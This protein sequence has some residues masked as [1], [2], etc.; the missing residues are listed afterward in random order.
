MWGRIMLHRSCSAQLAARTGAGKEGEAQMAADA[1]ISE[2]D[3][4]DVG[5]NNNKILATGEQLNKNLQRGREK[6]SGADRAL[7]PALS[8]AGSYAARSSGRRKRE[9]HAWPPRSMGQVSLFKA[10]LYRNQTI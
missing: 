9:D 1:L 5:N 10:W 3:L 7:T 2:N 6:G 4:S 8:R